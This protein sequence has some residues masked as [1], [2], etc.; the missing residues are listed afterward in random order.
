LPSVPTN[1]PGSSFQ[2][3]FASASG[4]G[5][6]REGT[7]SPDAA[8]RDTTT[9]DAKTDDGADGQTEAQP[10][11]QSGASTRAATVLSQADLQK[12]SAKNLSRGQEVGQRQS[13]GALGSSGTVKEKSAYPTSSESNPRATSAVTIAGSITV[14]AEQ[15]SRSYN[16]F[17]SMLAA[18]PTEAI[19]ENGQLTSEAKTQTFANTSS[20]VASISEM[21]GQTAAATDSI[22]R[23]GISVSNTAT[24]AVMGG[25]TGSPEQTESPLVPATVSA[26]ENV[27][28]SSTGQQGNLVNI[29]GTPDSGQAPSNGVSQSSGVAKAESLST[30]LTAASTNPST[31]TSIV[32]PSALP[33]ATAGWSY[34]TFQM[35]LVSASNQGIPAGSAMDTGATTYV[36]A[37]GTSKPPVMISSSDTFQ[38]ATANQSHAAAQTELA[39]GAGK[40]IAASSSVLPGAGA[41]ANATVPIHIAGPQE[42][43]QSASVA[44]NIVAHSAASLLPTDQKN[45]A[46]V[47][48]AKTQ[49]NSSGDSVSA[50]SSASGSTPKPESSDATSDGQALKVTQEIPQQRV[51][52]SSLPILSMPIEPAI[53]D[54][55]PAATSSG[56]ANQEPTLSGTLIGIPDLQSDVSAQSAGIA[57]QAPVDLSIAAV[58]PENGDSTQPVGKQVQKEASG[59]TGLKISSPAN[60]ANTGPSKA[61]DSANGSHDPSSHGAQNG[62]QSSQ[63][64]QSQAPATA[65]KT[66]DIAASQQQVPIATTHAVSQEIAAPHRAPDGAG[67]AARTTEER[68]VAASIHVDGEGTVTSGINTA[69]LLQTMSESEMHVG[70]HSA[71]FGNISIRTSVSQQQMVAQ[72]S[73]DHS[74]LS[75]AISAHVSSAQTKLGDEHGIHALIEVNNQ[76]ASSSGD[77][78]HSSQREQRAFVSSARTDSAV[79]AAEIDNG[80]NLGALVSV[81]NDQRLDIR[82]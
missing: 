33:A 23:V 73:V 22:G 9:S 15:I 80:M 6:S 28:A 20:R 48:A 59:G 50:S 27:V 18:A 32:I 78:G 4:E 60:T 2:A 1:R 68:D 41:S 79:G 38:P 69:K 24:R 65:S 19:S 11:A 54:A 13:E 42:Q 37:S 3:V 47:H 5:I 72:I 16:I 29:S 46:T 64:S 44:N 62:G 35:A 56:S 61:T 66:S 57:L 51:D 39:G 43:R 82:A 55:N 76:G 53:K 49:D 63:D 70:M 34:S 58:L 21:S 30:T 45:S 7:K 26:H 75:Q 10:A 40:A 71:E 12:A 17:Q 25:V 14:P 36:A 31:P 67:N 77:S 52:S 74:D 8:E 81:G